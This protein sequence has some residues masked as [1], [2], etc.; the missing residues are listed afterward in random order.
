[1]YRRDTITESK[2]IYI[3]QKYQNNNFL[4]RKNTLSL[5]NER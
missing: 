1:M 5:D 4:R 3:I 2:K